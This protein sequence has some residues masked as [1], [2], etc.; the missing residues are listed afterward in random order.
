MGTP[1]KPI[2]AA[3]CVVVLLVPVADEV[4]GVLLEDELLPHPA[5]RSAPL[6]KARIWDRKAIGENG[7]WW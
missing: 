3:L 2:W 4:A 7:S 6:I 5:S 1:S